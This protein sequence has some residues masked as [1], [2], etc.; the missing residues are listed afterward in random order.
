MSRVS[1]FH[2]KTLI[3]AIIVKRKGEEVLNFIQEG[4][5]DK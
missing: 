1:P 3:D 4:R 5:A 2:K